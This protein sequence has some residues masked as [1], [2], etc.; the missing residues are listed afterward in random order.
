MTCENAG[1]GCEVTVKLD[2]LPGHL[3]ECL[4][5]PKRPVPCV[6]GCGITVPKD[7]MEVG[8]LFAISLPI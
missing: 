4:H 1:S 8:S 7:E 2:L 5:N 3:K 6:Q